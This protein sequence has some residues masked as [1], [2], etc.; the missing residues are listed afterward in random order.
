[1]PGNNPSWILWLYSMYLMTMNP[2]APNSV[3]IRQIVTAT[4]LPRAANVTAMAM[5]I[6]L[7]SRTQVLSPPQNVSRNCAPYLKISGW[8]ARQTA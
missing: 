3:R 8:L 1:M 7:V 2:A 4:I 6:E 5:V